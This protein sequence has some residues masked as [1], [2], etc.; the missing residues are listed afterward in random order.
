MTAICFVCNLPIMS[1][2][3][4]L[5]WSGGNGWDDLMREQVN[6]TF[7]VLS[8]DISVSLPHDASC[9]DFFLGVWIDDSPAFGRPKGFS[10]SDF[11]S[12]AAEHFAAARQPQPATQLAR[13][14][15]RYPPRVERHWVQKKSK[16]A[17]EPTGDA[18]GFGTKP[19]MA[20]DKQWSIHVDARARSTVAKTT[21]VECRLRYQEHEIK[22]GLAHFRACED[23]E[24]QGRGEGESRD[25]KRVRFGW[26]I[27]HSKRLSTRL[28]WF[29]QSRIETWLDSDRRLGSAQSDWRAEEATWLVG[30]TRNSQLSSR[31]KTVDELRRFRP[32][33]SATSRLVI[34]V[35]SHADNN[36]EFRHAARHQPQIW[37]CK[38]RST[39]LNDAVQQPDEPEGIE[40]TTASN[41]LRWILR[42]VVV[43]AKLPTATASFESRGRTERGWKLMR[44][45]STTR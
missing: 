13:S 37:S 18:G 10:S 3:V 43:E 44:T 24:S 36:H 1:H 11:G 30:R 21:R 2:Q 20:P 38:I 16:A 22:T 40:A 35:N 8:N 29:E 14:A 19:A 26:N 15:H 12:I 7:Y 34:A 32:A 28:R 25:S 27:Q 4:G 33:V 41:S 23:L 31:A 17:L 5:V 9:N 45:T 42:A 39:G 6:L